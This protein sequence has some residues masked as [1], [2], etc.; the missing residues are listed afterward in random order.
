MPGNGR[1]HA[2]RAAVNARADTRWGAG[3]G[4]G[5][6]G[7]TAN[8]GEQ[9]PAAEGS[10]QER[11]FTQ[12]EVNR[13]VEGRVARVKAEPPADYDELKA[14]AARLDELEAAAKTDLQKAEERAAK[15]EAEVAGYKA[16]ESRREWNA[17]AAKATGVP[18]DVLANLSAES[19]G[20]LME[21][22]ESMKG[23]F[24]PPSA[25]VV[26][27]DGFAAATAEQAESANDWLR[28]TIPGFRR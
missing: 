8:A 23:Y 21:K 12:E 28:S 9:S 20:E 18:E 11:T 27:S 26:G 16:A 25:P 22:A 10:A 5:M 13:I 4:Q 19:E 3:K 1:H 14:K 2:T 15:A 7:S 6:P 24:A 17:K